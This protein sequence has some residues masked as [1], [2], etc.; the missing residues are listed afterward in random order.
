MMRIL[1]HTPYL[2]KIFFS[3]VLSLYLFDNAFTMGLVLILDQMYGDD[4]A[5]ELDP[6][7]EDSSS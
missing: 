4:D 2:E 3:C 6:T 7:L 1:F 5:Q